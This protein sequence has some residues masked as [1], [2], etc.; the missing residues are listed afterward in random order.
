LED[1]IKLSG[2]AAVQ[3]ARGNISPAEANAIRATL[4]EFRCLLDVR[5]QDE[6]LAEAKRAL[7][8]M[9]AIRDGA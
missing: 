6:K 2:W 5:D 1:A 3:V 4:A 9:R 8:E 7:A